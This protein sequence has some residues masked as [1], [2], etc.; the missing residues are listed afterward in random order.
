MEIGDTVIITPDTWRNIR[1]TNAAWR[2]KVQ[3]LNG[4]GLTVV[5]IT[6]YPDILVSDGNTNL[7]MP[8]HSLRIIK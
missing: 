7:Y 3:E 6:R 1:H 8:I 5:N 4:T 2:A